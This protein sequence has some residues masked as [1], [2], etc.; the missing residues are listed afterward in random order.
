[1]YNQGEGSGEGDPVG[2]NGVGI[3]TLDDGFNIKGV[4]AWEVLK[5]WTLAS[6]WGR[7]G[8]VLFT[9]WLN[10]TKGQHTKPFVKDLP[11]KITIFKFDAGPQG[12][13]NMVP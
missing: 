12:G 4:F 8:K 13:P 1:M 9:R 10:T 2:C 11:R 3:G 6:S 5:K 7:L